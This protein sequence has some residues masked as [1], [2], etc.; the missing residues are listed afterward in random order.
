M[1]SAK[2]PSELALWCVAVRGPEN[3]HTARP[4]SLSVVLRGEHTERWLYKYSVSSAEGLLFVSRLVVERSG[5]SPQ[6]V[7][8]HLS[9]DACNNN[10]F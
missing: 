10:R 7:L 4:C 3:G 1:S 6:M 2:H 9:K 8:V 5:L